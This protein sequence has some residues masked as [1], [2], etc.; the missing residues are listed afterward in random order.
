MV[1]FVFMIFISGCV[2]KLYF[3]PNELPNGRVG[4][5]YY[6]PVSVSGGSGAIVDF[7][8]EIQPDNSGLKLKFGTEE[9]HTK[10]LYNKF[11][12]EGK[13]LYPGEFYIK[14][15]GGMVGGAGQ[16]FEKTYNIK[17]TY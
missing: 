6:I 10:Y 15:K 1:F 16:G 13:P 2:S 5:M 8:Y 3:Q 11:I 4:E 17:V 12:V 7:H 9:Y 14:M